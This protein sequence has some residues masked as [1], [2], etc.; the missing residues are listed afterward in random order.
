MEGVEETLERRIRSAAA[1]RMTTHAIDDDQQHRFIIRGD[2]NSVL[3]VFPVSDQTQVSM[4]DPQARAP[5]ERAINC[6][7]LESV[8]EPCYPGFS[9]L[10]WSTSD[11]CGGSA[12]FS[13][14]GSRS[15]YLSGALYTGARS[16]LTPQLA[17]ADRLLLRELTTMS[18]EL[19]TK[20]L[21]DLSSDLRA[22]PVLV[23]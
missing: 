9:S 1:V 3:I 10:P 7:T 2:G 19:A 22:S 11:G 23:A 20:T 13:D 17:T 8:D 14:T 6:Y 4:L 12:G 21:V 5:A 16:Q 18:D 15:E